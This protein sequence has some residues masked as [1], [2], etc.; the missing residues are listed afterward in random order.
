MN[1]PHVEKLIYKL[2]VG[3][4]VD[5]ERATPLSEETNDFIM[6][7][8]KN[9]V[10][11]EMKT[12]CATLEEAK[13][14]VKSYIKAWEIVI[15]LEYSPDELCFKFENAKIIDRKP[16]NGKGIIAAAGT[17]RLSATVNATLQVKRK[18][19]PSPPKD[20]IVS[21]LLERIYAR[22][23][24]FRLGRE[25]IL[26]MGYLALNTIE[27]FAKEKSKESN[28]QNKRE[29]AAEYFKIDKEVLDYLGQLTSEHGDEME[30]RKS[31]VGGEFPKPLKPNETEWID[32]AIKRIIY[33]IGQHKYNSIN[34][35]Q[36]TMTD[37]PPL[38]D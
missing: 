31:G 28:Q 16:F 9:N 11:F 17:F 13:L 19:Y 10:V 27:N 15:G 30:A 3:E 12:H 6:K 7:I 1:D 37:L 35:K 21:P 14:V 22:Y 18:K 5:Y 8:I 25:K 24:E 2:I 36:L 33:Q 4:N 26:P 38:K 29:L 20:F 23:K 32:A 34:L